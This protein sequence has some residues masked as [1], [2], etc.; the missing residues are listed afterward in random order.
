MATSKTSPELVS[1]KEADYLD[2]DPAL[3]GQ[4]F[5]CL[6]FLPNGEVIRNKDVFM[7][8]RFLTSFASEL[9]EFFTNTKER[10]KD[11][12]VVVDMLDSIKER[13]DYIFNENA[14]QHEYDHYKRMNS[15]T[16]EKD[17]FE[18]NNFQ[19]S[20]SGLKVRG[21]YDTYKE[22]TRRAEQIQQ[23]DKQFHVF[24][25]Q[26][27]CWLPWSPYPDD[28]EDQQYSE[29]TLNTLMKK[30]KEGQDLKRELY[31]LRKNDLV[32]KIKMHPSKDEGEGSSTLDPIKESDSDEKLSSPT[33]LAEDDPWVKKNLDQNDSE[34][35]AA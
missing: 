32:N 31:E 23:F 4:N 22:A 1:V 20:M 6:S 21:V 26:V 17:Y 5:V 8:N 11:D 13:Y 25:G 27:G 19:T 30:Y 3:R 24:V 7:F 9:G 33:D 10:F 12:N 34:Q 14:L 16:L 15:E 28:I 29:T 18:K 35:T 2:Q